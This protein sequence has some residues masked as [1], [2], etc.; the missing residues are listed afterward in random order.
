[1][2]FCDKN[3]L[4]KHRTCVFLYYL[5]IPKITGWLNP[6]LGLVTS[7]HDTSLCHVLDLTTV[8]KHRISSY[9]KLTLKKH[10]Y[11]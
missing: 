8:C 4:W 6:P 5:R 9:Y 2:T 10:T 3:C 11:S 7:P 1:M